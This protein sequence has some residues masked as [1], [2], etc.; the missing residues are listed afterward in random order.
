[1]KDIKGERLYLREI[2]IEDI[3]DSVSAWFEDDELMKYYTSSKNKITKEK[4]ISSIE[5]GKVAGDLFTFGIFTNEDNKLI[6]TIKLGPINFNHKISDLVA[7]IGDRNYL[8]KGLS[9]DAIQ[10]GNK[11]AFDEFDIRKLY[12]GMYLSNIASI[13]AY[14]RAGWVIEGRLKGFYMIEES[15]EDRL[16]VGCFNP[17]YFTEEEINGIKKN[18]NRYFPN[19]Q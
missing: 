17:K 18:E 19:K 7:L 3:T 6:G 8:G 16:L 2:Q 12:G 10:L 11:L 13:K 15:N 14:T 5:F 9:V 4:L 1:M